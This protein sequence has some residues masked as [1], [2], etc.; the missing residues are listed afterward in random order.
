[1]GIVITSPALAVDGKVSVFQ[2]TLHQLF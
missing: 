1:M 2:Q